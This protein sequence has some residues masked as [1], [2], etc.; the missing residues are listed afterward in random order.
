MLKSLIRND[1]TDKD[2]VHSYIEVYDDLFAKKRDSAAR[3]LE[4]GIAGGG[5]IKLWHD[6]FK[7]AT[8]HG[9]DIMP[10]SKVWS[11]IKGKERIVLHTESDA[12]S[13]KFIDSL[14]D[15]RFDIIVDDGSHALVD[16]VHFI[17]KYVP[18]LAN[19]GILVVEDVVTDAWIPVLRASVPTEL[20][21]NIQVFDRRKLKGRFDDILFVVSK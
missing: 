17:T 10:A 21:G 4:V 7:N 12:Y 2:T 20:Q 15:K 3:V 19:D 11:E 13:D 16:M 14:K 6:Y 5:S 8:V 18:L 1:R 9:V